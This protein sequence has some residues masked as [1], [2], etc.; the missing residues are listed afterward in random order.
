M[1]TFLELRD[2]AVGPDGA[3]TRSLTEQDLIDI[4]NAVWAHPKAL[5][6]ARFLGLK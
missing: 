1:A 4:A 6:L 3:G 5:T 2:L